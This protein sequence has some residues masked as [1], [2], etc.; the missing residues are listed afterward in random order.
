M[1]FQ[2]VHDL[3]LAIYV[4]YYAKEENRTGFVGHLCGAIAGFLVGTFVLDNRRVQRWEV[5]W[6]RIA[7]GIFL[8]LIAAAILWNGV[9]NLC[10]NNSFF[11]P[12][13]FQA[14]GDDSGNCDF[15]L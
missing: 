8:T 7:L 2:I 1:Y 14:L 3:G 10:T 5:L 11:P 4:R 12:S 6:Q 15:Y 9:G 13:D